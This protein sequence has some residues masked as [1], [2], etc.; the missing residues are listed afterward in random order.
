[1]SRAN[2]RLAA[3]I[4]LGWSAVAL[5]LSLQ[6]YLTSADG[7]RPQAWW[8]SLG[9]AFAIFSVWAALTW[10]VLAG[11]RAVEGSG[12]R[13]PLR[14]ALYAA[15]LFAVA[16]L[17]VALFVAVYWPLYN[18][19]GRLP[20]LAMAERMFVRN[21]GTDALFYAALVGL[22][23]RLRRRPAPVV[24]APDVLR[25]R[26]RGA[27]RIVPLADVDWIGAAGN[28]AEA[29]TAAG[30][31]LLDESLGSLAARLP[32]G[33]ARIHRGA[34]VRL[35]RIAEVRRLGRGD[36]EVILRSGASLRLSRRYRPALSA[37]LNGD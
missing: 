6:G 9:Y 37:W 10:P 30:A 33:F 25:A 17:H 3:A 31:V 32:A 1:M 21:L 15:G 4:V 22:G 18:D 29:H 23:L 20:R 35:D 11:V 12:L 19:A 34:I 28:Y 26:S 7:G 36:A 16:G 5:L 8:P 13:L 24:P 2:L 27:V 14:L